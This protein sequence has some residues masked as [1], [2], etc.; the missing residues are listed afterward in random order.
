[1]RFTAVDVQ[2]ECYIGMNIHS[3][4]PSR[5]RNADSTD[6]LSQILLV[7]NQIKRRSVERDLGKA[8]E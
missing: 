5:A 7:R 3:R 1:L 8:Q 2:L 6:L 4:K